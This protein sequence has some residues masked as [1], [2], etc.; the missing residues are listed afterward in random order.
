[1]TVAILALLI[2]APAVVMGSA[3]NARELRAYATYAAEKIEEDDNY[4][5]RGVLVRY[6]TPGHA[7]VSHLEA[8]VADL[9]LAV[10]NGIWL[11]GLC[12]TRPGR[13]GC[14]C[15]VTTTIRW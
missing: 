12:R 1:M 4:A 15:G 2:V 10:V 9:P 3:A 13:P 5:L 6:L 7:D 14:R 11:A 8:S